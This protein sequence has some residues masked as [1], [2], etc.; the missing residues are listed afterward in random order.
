LSLDTRTG[1]EDQE[2][3][4]PQESKY[5]KLGVNQ[6]LNNYA[7]TDA[8]G[9][10]Q[11]Q[12]V[13]ESNNLVVLKGDTDIGVF[14]FTNTAGL[15]PGVVGKRYFSSNFNEMIAAATIFATV[16]NTKKKKNSNNNKNK[17]KSL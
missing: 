2:L 9:R 14:D 15:P 6:G 16:D 10:R 1:S 11:R 5:K 7:K 3:S 17:N 8:A 13:S 12:L 4:D